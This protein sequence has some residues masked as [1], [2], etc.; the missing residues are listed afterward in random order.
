VGKRSRKQR[1]AAP[2]KE[3]RGPEPKP[4][5]ERPSVTRAK[6]AAAREQLALAREEQAAEKPPSRSEL[7][8]AEARAKLEPLAPGERPR[9]VL[10]GAVVTAIVGVVN[11][12]M[13]VAGA[14]IQ[15]QRP[16]P[17]GILAFTG[18]MF[19]MAWGL[20]RARYWAVLGLEALLGI[21]LLIFSL[22]ALRVES[23]ADVLI[24]VGVLIPSGALFWFLIKAMARIQMPERPG[25][26][27]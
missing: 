25:S 17:A 18:L 22:F 6:N 14:K 5:P 10:V 1:S 15:G 27:R 13:Y 11:L 7:K 2:A 26:R 3:R 8:N 24:S 20:W 9:A 23:A 4:W 12:V 16:A 21:V 19:A